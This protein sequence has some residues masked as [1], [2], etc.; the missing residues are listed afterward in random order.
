MINASWKKLLVPL[1][2]ILMVSCSEEMSRNK[3][4]DVLVEHYKFPITVTKE[5]DLGKNIYATNYGMNLEILKALAAEKIIESSPNGRIGSVSLTDYG[6]GFVQGEQKKRGWP[7]E[8]QA[9]VD[10]AIAKKELVEITGLINRDEK[11]SIIDYTWQYVPFSKDWK[12]PIADLARMNTS[13]IH[14]DQA[15]LVLYD[16]GWRVQEM[17]KFW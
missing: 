10:I 1:A 12:N 16:D 5:L 2:C 7:N 6:K 11:T 3:A 9:Y 8:G 4:K 13:T 15:V 17:P 14:K